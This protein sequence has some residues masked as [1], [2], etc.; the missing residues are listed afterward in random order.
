MC[1]EIIYDDNWLEPKSIPSFGIGYKV[2]ELHDKK[3]RGI[4]GVKYE[5]RKDG[6]IEWIEHLSNSTS[7]GREGFC[8]FTTKKEVKRML[9]DWNKLNTLFNYKE[10]YDIMPIEYREGVMSRLEN[11]II[12]GNTY[13]IALCKQFKIIEGG[14]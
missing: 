12:S 7:P 9:K 10:K 11:N 8:F 13:R 5:E 4:M 3:I 1:N 14:K 2:F 6:W